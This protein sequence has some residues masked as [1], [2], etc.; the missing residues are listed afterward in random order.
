MKRHETLV[1][2]L[3]DKLL[4]IIRTNSFDDA[5][6]I[7]DACIEGGIEIIEV[8]FTYS[9]AHDIIRELS[10]KYKETD[11]MLGA[12]TI[13]DAETARIALLN[14]A[15]FIISPSL[16]EDVIKLCNRYNK[17]S[18]P[19]VMTVTEIKKA[20]ELG[21]EL[22]K[23][24]PAAT[25]GVDFIRS[26]KAP[27]PQVMIMPTGG[28]SLENATCWLEAGSSVLGIGG[29]LTNVA[30]NGDFEKI[31]EIARKFRDVIDNYKLREE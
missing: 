16:N 22:V 1:K 8:T 31:T 27:I 9:R 23:V 6:K 5:L 18:I 14:G 30:E 3:D 25:L 24:F 13:L 19:G 10:K 4:G 26:I 28:I 21:V 7:A 12:G 29:N 17:L 11:V 15:E 20:L 2:M